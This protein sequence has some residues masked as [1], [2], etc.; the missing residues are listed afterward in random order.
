MSRVSTAV[1]LACHGE[2]ERTRRCLENLQSFLPQNIWAGAH[3]F[4]VD[5]LCPDWSAKAAA[6]TWMGAR[7]VITTEKEQFWARSMALAERAARANRARWDYLLWLNQ[8]TVA[9]SH[10][11]SLFQPDKIVAGTCEI[12][13]R[14]AKGALVEDGHKCRFRLAKENET[15][16]TFN[17]NLTVVPKQIFTRLA[18]EQYA[19]AFADLHYGLEATALGFQIERGP[20]CAET[21]PQKENWRDRETLEARWKACM[22]PRGLPPA[23]W[24]KFCRRFSGP[25]APARFLWAYRHIFRKRKVPKPLVRPEN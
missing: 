6:E 1:L 23:D 16:V 7:T 18:I 13:G 14:P 10:L 2:A 17:G 5:D 21:S 19:H 24:W 22:A 12:S 4:I 15:P 8:D 3:L 25:S 11:G 9:R 20:V